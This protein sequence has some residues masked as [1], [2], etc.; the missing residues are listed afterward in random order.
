M[1]LSVRQLAGL[2]GMI[3]CIL[4]GVSCG[5]VSLRTESNHDQTAQAGEQGR[6]VSGEPR[7]MLDPSMMTPQEV[8]AKFNFDPDSLEPGEVCVINSRDRKSVV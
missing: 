6:P 2:V 3:S 5:G 8:N 7:T 1:K 4:L